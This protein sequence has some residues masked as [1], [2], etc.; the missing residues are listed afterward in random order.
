MKRLI[1][2][3]ALVAVILPAISHGAEAT[4]LDS[5]KNITSWSRGESKQLADYLSHSPRDT[6]RIKDDN[7]RNTLIANCALGCSTRGEGGVAKLGMP[8]VD[9]KVWRDACMVVCPLDLTKNYRSYLKT[10]GY[11]PPARIAF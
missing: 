6:N 4:L 3:A 1:R 11:Q 7:T 5:A 9:V 2:L 8:G 10:K